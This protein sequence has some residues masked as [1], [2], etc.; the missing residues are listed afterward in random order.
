MEKGLPYSRACRGGGGV[1][2]CWPS[3]QIAPPR[4][5]GE[6][7][8]GPL[9]CAWEGMPSGLAPGLPQGCGTGGNMQQ[10]RQRSSAASHSLRCG[11][12]HGSEPP[13][14]SRWV[15][16]LRSPAATL[17][18]ARSLA[19]VPAHLNY[20]GHGDGGVGPGKQHLVRLLRATAHTNYGHIIQLLR[21]A[22]AGICR[23]RALSS[24]TINR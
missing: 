20:F 24:R 7:H 9:P 18:H 1:L 13:T 10:R 23:Y 8:G 2:G 22:G 19:A 21:L 11:S 15:E 5:N 3:A 16:G 12:L 4:P 17:S 14:H 6:C